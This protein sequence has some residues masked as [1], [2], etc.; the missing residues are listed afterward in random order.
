[1]FVKDYQLVL[2]NITMEQT[3]ETS[4][5]NSKVKG[6]YRRAMGLG[7]TVQFVLRV[8]KEAFLPP[9]EFNEIIR[10]A[11]EVGFKSIFPVSITALGMGIV[12]VLQS[13]P[14][15][16]E[17]GAGSYIPSMAAV[18][19]IR[20]IGPL[21]T[22]LVCA[23]NI[24]SNITA[25]LGSMKISD[26]ID[27]MEVSGINPFKYLVV[28][29][30]ISST[31]IIPILVIHA[32]AISLIGSFIGANV[33]GQ[34]S[35]RLFF[36]QVV[37]K[38]SFNDIAPSI[39]KSFIF[40]FIIGIVGCYKGYTSENGTAG[41]GKATNASVINSLMLVIITDMVVTQI[42]NIFNLL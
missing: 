13:R 18:S 5:Q 25:E 36:G 35:L 10:Q 1:M 9:F 26:Q 31:L 21:I 19:I 2:R 32:D 14:A 29:R 23:G 11:Y 37:E 20:E 42:S 3:E 6:L 4:V 34:I 39:I 30:V 28:T 41:V 38:L 17:F 22:A 40:G 8:I 16:V 15:L 12:L 7:D 24:G 27:A 33:K